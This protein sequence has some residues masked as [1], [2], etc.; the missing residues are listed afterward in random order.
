[1][2]QLRVH[3]R[4]CGSTPVCVSFII[5]CWR[6]AA[7]ILSM[8]I[9]R[10]FRSLTSV[11]VSVLLRVFNRCCPHQFSRSRFLSLVSKLCQEDFSFQ[12]QGFAARGIFPAPY[13]ENGSS[14][15][16]PPAV[17]SLTRGSGYGTRPTC[18]RPYGRG[19]H[20]RGSQFPYF[21][22]AAWICSTLLSSKSKPFVGPCCF[23]HLQ[24]T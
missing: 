8:S 15:V 3:R 9:Q 6:P 21:A 2:P 13:L 1:V 5:R 19:Q 22:S 20:C 24:D 16:L 18:Q 7:S 12:R 11:L 4:C 10:H 17:A 14:I 23:T